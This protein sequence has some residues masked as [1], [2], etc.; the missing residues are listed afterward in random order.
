M[1]SPV[2]TQLCCLDSLL[3]FDI[4]ATSDR[5]TSG[6][7]LNS[8]TARNLPESGGL[9]TAADHRSEGRQSSK[10]R[11]DQSRQFTC[12]RFKRTGSTEALDDFGPE[13]AGGFL[14]FD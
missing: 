14:T 2:L 7:N 9:S 1:L 8:T 11:S 10:T 13:R 6:S 4:L 3:N 12:G 5:M